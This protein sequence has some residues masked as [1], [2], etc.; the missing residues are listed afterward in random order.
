MVNIGFLIITF[1]HTYLDTCINSIRKFYKYPI[2]IVDNDTSAPNYCHYSDVNYIKNTGNY[3][4]LGAIWHG[5]KIF[6]DIEK[7][8]IL[9]N[10]MILLDTL[11]INIESCNFISYWKTVSADYSP[12]IPW[13]ENKLKQ[14]NLPFENDKIWYSVTGVS[15]IIDTC[16]L[17]KLIEM[18]YDKIYAT[19]KI[20][21]VGTEILFGY[22]ISNVLKLNNRSIYNYPLDYY[23]QKKENFT[24]IA[25]IGS[26]QGVSSPVTNINLSNLIFHKILNVIPNENLNT[27]YIDLINI[28]DDDLNLQQAIMDTFNYGILNQPIATVFG[29]VRHRMF[30]KKY[31]PTYYEQE[32][33]QI[34]SGQKNL[35]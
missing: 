34:I 33:I 30:T 7:F 26:G 1:G 27:Y 35:F 29:A 18:G 22:L 5:C 11:P 32:K 15:C 14:N 4:E 20:E 19:Q 2:Y 13:V 9:H 17:K 28:V 31:F 25:K 24:C 10:S 3:Y 16:Y 12:A 21:A 23:Y 8:I 6:S